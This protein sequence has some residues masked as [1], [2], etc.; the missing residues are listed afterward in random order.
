MRG[1]RIIIQEA[2]RVRSLKIRPPSF[3]FCE[4]TLQWHSGR[5][6]RAV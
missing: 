4:A 2:V 1:M 6:Y 5:F 3:M